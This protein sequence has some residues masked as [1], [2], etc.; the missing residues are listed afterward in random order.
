[1]QIPSSYFRLVWAL[2]NVPA[3]KGALAKDDVLFG[4]VETWILH[5]L[6]GGRLHLTDI[7]NAAAT[8]DTFGPNWYCCNT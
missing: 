7:S 5:K 8:G 4:T 1:M 3:L 6:T 2:Q